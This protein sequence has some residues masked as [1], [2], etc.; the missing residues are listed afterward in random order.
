MPGGLWYKD[1]Y[2]YIEDM[3]TGEIIR[4]KVPF[5]VEKSD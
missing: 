1:G 5:K 4:F 3:Y 2:N